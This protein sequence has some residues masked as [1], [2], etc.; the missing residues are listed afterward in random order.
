MSSDFAGMYRNLG[1]H[2]RP[3]QIRT[4][5][6]HHDTD[7]DEDRPP[8]PHNATAAIT[9]KTRMGTPSAGKSALVVVMITT[10]YDVF[11]AHADAQNPKA[12][13]NRRTVSAAGRLQSRSSTR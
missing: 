6:R 3:G 8:V 4:E 11:P 9:M 2:Q 1:G 10:R 5:H 12:E 13:L 7:A